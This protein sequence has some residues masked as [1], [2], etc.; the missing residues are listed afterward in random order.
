LTAICKKECPNSGSCQLI[1]LKPEA[2][3]GQDE[4]QQLMLPDRKQEGEEWPV[5]EREGFVSCERV[6]LNVCSKL[7]ELV[8]YYSIYLSKI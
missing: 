8:K 4:S 6:K 7:V 5:E 3:L 1:E 2:F